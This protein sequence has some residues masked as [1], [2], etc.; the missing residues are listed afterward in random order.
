MDSFLTVERLQL[1]SLL[2]ALLLIGFIA[3]LLTNI[4]LGWGMYHA[5]NS[6]SR[7]V[8]PPQISKAFTI[9]DTNIDESYLQQMSEYFMHLRLDV[10]PAS[11][12]RKYSIL[13]DYVTAEDWPTV[14]PKLLR[15]AEHVKSQNISSR[16]DVDKVEIALEDLEVRLTGVLQKHV[17]SRP[18]AP[19][20]ATYLVSLRYQHGE[21]SVPSIQRIKSTETK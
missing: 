16:F 8:V 6:K 12:H 10:T 14:Q 15:E 19:E 5:V 3:M 4:A 2:N 1:K 7:T 21:I 13:L 9:S 18:L 20:T 11:V 17:G